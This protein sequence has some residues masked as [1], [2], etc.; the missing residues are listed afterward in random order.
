[1]QIAEG[2]IGHWVVN[3]NARP[4]QAHKGD[5]QANARGNGV[6]QRN[7]QHIHHLF[8]QTD[9]GDQNEKYP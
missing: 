2:D 3:D 7:R 1:M 8:A 6:P 9:K 5:E 4:F